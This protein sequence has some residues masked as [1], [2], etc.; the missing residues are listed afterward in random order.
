MTIIKD[1]LTEL[2]AMFVGDARLTAALLVVV[3]ITAAMVDIM[4]LPDLAGGSVLLLG[5]LGVLVESVRRE[6]RHRRDQH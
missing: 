3:A 2:F 5:S 1:V 6:A 4:G